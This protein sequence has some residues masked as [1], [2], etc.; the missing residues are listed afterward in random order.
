[1]E[2]EKR[3]L[4]PP[5]ERHFHVRTRD[6]KLFHLHYRG[7]EEMWTLIELIEG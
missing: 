2:I 4:E 7:R 1:V 3:W 6:N 5:W